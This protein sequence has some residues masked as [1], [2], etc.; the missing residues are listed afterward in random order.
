M[1]PEQTLQVCCMPGGHIVSV[2][3]QPSMLFPAQDLGD[4]LLV[5]FIDLFV[6]LFFSQHSRQFRQFD[7]EAP[8]YFAVSAG[9]FSAPLFICSTGHQTQGFLHALPLS[10]TPLP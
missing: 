2:L 4:L 9:S 7:F 1:S 8:F 10:C 3:R 5:L 6:T